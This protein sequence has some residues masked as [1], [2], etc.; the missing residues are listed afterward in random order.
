MQSYGTVS[1]QDG[2]YVQNEIIQNDRDRRGFVRYSEEKEVY[3]KLTLNKNQQNK[4]FVIDL[5]YKNYKYVVNS[6]SVSLT[7]I[8]VDYEKQYRVISSNKN[9]AKEIKSLVSNFSNCEEAHKIRK[10]IIALQKIKS[11]ISQE[12]FKFPIT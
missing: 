6:G 3:P 1:F 10:R 11:S 5:F 7:T 12:L 8:P 2:V 4:S 9:T